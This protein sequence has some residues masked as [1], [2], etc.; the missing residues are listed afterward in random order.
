M[1]PILKLIE[2]LLLNL[3]NKNLDEFLNELELADFPLDYLNALNKKE[4]LMH[5]ANP[6]IIKNGFYI[7]KNSRV[8]Y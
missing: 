2:P 8:F 3:N 7:L 5:R 1:K 4:K 6:Y